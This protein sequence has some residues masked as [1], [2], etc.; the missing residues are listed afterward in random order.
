MYYTYG[1]GS[2]LGET[3]FD[4]YTSADLKHWSQPFP[5]FRAPED[6]WGDRDFW[7]PEVH[8]YNGRYYLFGSFSAG[9]GSRGTHILASDSPRGPFLPL[10]ER[11]Q[12]PADW[13]CL[14][15]TLYVDERDTPW[16]VFCHEWVQVTD[17]RM[18]AVRLTDDLSAAVGEP[19][20][21]FRASQAPWVRPIG[22]DPRGCV[23]DGPWLH[24]LASG[25][26]I[27]LW[28]SFDEGGNY[29]LA[30]ARSASGTLAGPWEHDLEPLFSEDGGHGMLFTTFDGKKMISFH[31]PNHGAPARPIF[32][33]IKE[34]ER[35]IRILNEE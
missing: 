16:M 8:R 32:R 34:T 10:G 3:G 18:C 28:A 23:T 19:V 7:A 31:K 13:M 24:R 5:V 27:M 33:H 26:L 2:P 21:L 4:A 22:V 11:A 29:G 17:G 1:T 14:D 15:G 25:V 20:E 35:G 9:P 12:T 30:L 6:F